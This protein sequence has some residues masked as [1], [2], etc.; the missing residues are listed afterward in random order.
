MLRVSPSSASGSPRRRTTRLT[1][2]VAKHFLTS[3]ES[4]NA[5]AKHWAQAYAQAPAKRRAK[6]GNATDA[7]MAG[8]TEE[9]V[10]K[11]TD[12]GFDRPTVVSCR[13]RAA[14][15]VSHFLLQLKATGMEELR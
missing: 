5:T 7:E 12:M 15:V 2:S 1:P 4:F 13:E 8:L 11:F 9:S 10:V 3:R 14:A 6:D